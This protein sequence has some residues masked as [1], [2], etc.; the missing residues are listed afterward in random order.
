MRSYLK[1]DMYKLILNLNHSDG[2]L[3]LLLGLSSNDHLYKY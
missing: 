3:A 2:A 1:G